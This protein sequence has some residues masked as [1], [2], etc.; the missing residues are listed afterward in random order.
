MR[1]SVESGESNT[2]AVGVGVIATNMAVSAEIMKYNEL[3]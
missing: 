3:S 2:M 1:R